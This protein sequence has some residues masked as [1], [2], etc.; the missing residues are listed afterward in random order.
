[1][2]P[3]RTPA[4][5]APDVVIDSWRKEYARAVHASKRPL[6][7]ALAQLWA[8]TPREVRELVV[9]QSE[10][11]AHAAGIF[12]ASISN[13][14]PD[15][16]A[17][18]AEGLERLAREVVAEQAGATDGAEQYC[19]VPER[20]GSGRLCTCGP[21]GRAACS[22]VAFDVGRGEVEPW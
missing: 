16:A 20:D 9:F 3:Q 22:S 14:V 6:D 11:L 1:M 15:A 5:D 21:E 18:F 4:I 12:L 17:L 8:R 7:P 2:T 13:A 10:A 19:P